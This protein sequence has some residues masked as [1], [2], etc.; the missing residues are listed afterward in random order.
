MFQGLQ[1]YKGSRLLHTLQIEW[2]IVHQS[3]SVVTFTISDD[4]INK[5]FIIYPQNKV[6]VLII[7]S[8]IFVN[9]N[10]Y[11]SFGGKTHF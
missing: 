9:D 5:I 10:T 3:V 1:V 4:L 11:N 6:S 7:W 8:A 2:E